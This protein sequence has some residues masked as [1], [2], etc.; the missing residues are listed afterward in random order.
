[1]FTIAVENNGP[2]PAGSSP[3]HRHPARRAHVRVR[4]AR[5]HR[6]RPAPS[7]APWASYP[8]RR[9]TNVTITAIADRRRSGADADQRRLGELEHDRPEPCRQPEQRRRSRSR[10]RR[11]RRRPRAPSPALPTPLA[12]AP[13]AGAAAG[14][15][16]Q[17][18]REQGDR[19]RRT[20]RHLRGRRLQRTAL[21]KPPASRS[22]TRS[23]R[24]RG[25]HDRSR[26]AAPQRR[27]P[28]PA[29]SGRSRQ[30]LPGRS[31]SSSGRR[32]RSPGRRSPT[33]RRSPETSPTRPRQTTQPGDDHRPAARR[34]LRGRE[35]LAGPAR[36][37]AARRPTPHGRQ[38]RPRYA[39]SAS[40]SPTRLPRR[41]TEVSATAEPGEL[42]DNRIRRSQLQ[43][44]DLR[45]RR[46]IQVTIG[47]PRCQI[48]RRKDPVGLA[49]A[50]R[51]RSRT[52]T[53]RTTRRP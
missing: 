40:S 13:A 46:P 19:R 42:H 51:G 27:R 24:T 4:L 36:R 3:G 31:R 26:P 30:A 18:D 37:R 22:P 7:P 34:P 43:A 16:R 23:A 10:I 12:P 14:S 17:Q 32:P 21:E 2:D 52:R 48:A 20:R 50:H 39:P 5:L 47:R 38:P 9:P 8:T 29:P 53:R 25:R 33:S 45:E 11:L 35:R 41:L 44:R 6:S 15:R 28:S 1:M 49:E